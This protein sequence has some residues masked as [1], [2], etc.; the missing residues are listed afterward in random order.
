MFKQYAM[1]TRLCAVGVVQSDLLFTCVHPRFTTDQ[2][3]T[4]AARSIPQDTSCCS[5][6]TVVYSSV[7]VSYTHLDVYKRQAHL[8]MDHQAEDTRYPGCR[9]AWLLLSKTL[10]A[11][12]HV[13]APCVDQKLIVVRRPNR[14]HVL[15]PV[16]IQR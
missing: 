2:N 12:R 5:S 3:K 10:S 7:S 1:G 9:L 15:N 8:M 14:H 16:T 13:S 4:H 6:L 11:S